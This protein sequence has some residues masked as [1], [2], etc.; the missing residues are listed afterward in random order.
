MKSNKLTHLLLLIATAT[1]LHVVQILDSVMLEKDSFL[2]LGN[3][4]EANSVSQ[5]EGAFNQ[6]IT[7]SITNNFENYEFDIM[8]FDL[9]DG[10]S[11]DLD[12]YKQLST[13]PGSDC[14]FDPEITSII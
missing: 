9:V 1:A 12:C 7:V 6:S 3:Y 13:K 4:N 11:K 10:E 8:I 14:Q 2:Q 5:E